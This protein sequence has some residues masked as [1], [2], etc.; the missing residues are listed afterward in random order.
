MD[1]KKKKGKNRNIIK[2]MMGVGNN[3]KIQ[4]VCYIGHGNSFNNRELLE[5]LNKL[6]LDHSQEESTSPQTKFNMR[7][8][9]EHMRKIKK[10]KKV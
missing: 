7:S 10:T 6:E 3:R 1:F 4:G 9:E 5:K 8:K 2:D